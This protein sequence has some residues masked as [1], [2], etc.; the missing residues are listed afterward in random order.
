MNFLFIYLFFYATLSFIFDEGLYINR[1]SH[2]LWHSRT[3]PDVSM[4]PL[5]FVNWDAV[6]RVG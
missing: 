5:Q 6:A 2:D 1:E 3:E 4:K